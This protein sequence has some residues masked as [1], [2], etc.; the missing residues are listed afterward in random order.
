[1]EQDTLM[2]LK[3]Y[4]S[5]SKS[6]SFWRPNFLSCGIAM[7]LF[8]SAVKPG[9]SDEF[10]TI[11]YS[12]VIALLREYSQ[13]IGAIGL[14]CLIYVFARQPKLSSL[15]ITYPAIWLLIFKLVLALRLIAAPAHG[16]D[17]LI[18]F[19]SISFLYFI[20]LARDGKYDCDVNYSSI[21]KGMYYFTIIIL[22]LNFYLYLFE[23]STTSWKG[24][25]IGVFH[26]PNFT[27]VNFA[28]CASI[29]FG[30]SHSQKNITTNK[31]ISKISIFLL[32][33]SIILIM[34]SGSR[35]GILGFIAA[36]L[37]YAYIQKLLKAKTIILLAFISFI[38]MISLNSIIELLAYYI[39]GVDRIIQAGNTRDAVWALMWNDFVSHPVFGSG[40]IVSGTA[41]S[42]LRV[43]AIGGIV[44][45][46]PL[47]ACLTLCLVRI[48]RNR[49]GYNFRKAWLPGLLC[50]LI[51]SITEGHLADALSLALIYFVFIVFALSICHPVY[52]Q[53]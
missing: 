34:A 18:S 35:T 19:I 9:L 12:G 7:F 36:F 26:H 30:F 28:I 45:G 38:I 50:I 24:R 32:A 8:A 39:P 13:Y 11:S 3:T 16:L 23:Y 41:G 5:N 20:F 51:T 40:S 14:L 15:K 33:L 10:D 27:G 46:L 1:M 49:G 4:Y 42:Y 6:R 37:G 44:S 53:N 21:L 43:L 25:F 31:S 22:L 47:L 52:R 17:Q 29:I 2:T 48:R